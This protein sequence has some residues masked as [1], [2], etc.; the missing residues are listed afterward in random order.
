MEWIKNNLPIISI[1]LITLGIVYLTSYY[2]C[3]GVDISSYLE[4][5][6]IIQLQFKYF[7]ATFC[8]IIIV[9]IS[10]IIKLNSK[11]DYNKSDKD[12]IYKELLKPSDFQRDNIMKHIS[13]DT[14]KQFKIAI[15]TSCF[16]VIVVTI[17]IAITKHYLITSGIEIMFMMISIYFFTQIALKHGKLFN[18]FGVSEK[19]KLLITYGSIYAFISIFLTFEWARLEASDLILKH[20]ES[21]LTIFFDN[22]SVAT[23]DSL[24]FVGKTKN[25]IFLYNRFTSK[26]DV[27]PFSTVKSIQ[28]RPGKKYKNI[29]YQYRIGK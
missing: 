26:A 12:D 21:E 4:F 11:R 2:L 16:M 3:F 22:K 29:P 23:N 6:E 18:G 20:S 9:N 28:Y 8:G 19:H 24:V 25:Y 14:S 5:S 10:T 13:K 15:I 27:Y 1:Y 7:A 17:Y